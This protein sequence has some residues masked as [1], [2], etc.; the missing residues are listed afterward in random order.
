MYERMLDKNNKPTIEMMNEYCKE[1]TILFIELNKWLSSKYDTVQSIAFLNYGWSVSHKRKGKLI[2]NIFP[3]NGSFT[4]ML[5]LSNSLLSLAYDQV[6]DK[7]ID[8]ICLCNDDGWVCF[9][10][11]NNQ[12]L[13]DI[14]TILSIKCCNN[15]LAAFDRLEKS[16]KSNKETIDYDKER[17]AAISDK[18]GDF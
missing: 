16:R 17:Q 18:Y 10:V 3:E 2:C 11:T 6:G 15:K 14:K 9:H 8:N 7:C 5:R 1:T 4:I 12:Q 13:V